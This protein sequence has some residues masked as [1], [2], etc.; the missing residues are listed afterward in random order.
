MVESTLTIGR[1]WL[2]RP[3]IGP[4]RN[5]DYRG[6]PFRT[7]TVLTVPD[8]AH[9]NAK[10]QY[11]MGREGILQLPLKACLR[12][13]SREVTWERLAGDRPRIKSSR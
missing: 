10:R 2:Y 11:L 4:D 13:M 6:E 7:V 9:D 3:S 12:P 5:V 8:D 1:G